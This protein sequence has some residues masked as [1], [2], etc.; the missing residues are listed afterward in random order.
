MTKADLI[1]SIC[2]D[3]GGF[4]RKEAAAITEVVFDAMKEALA[5]GSHLKLSGFGTFAVR[6]KRPRTGRNPRTGQ[7]MTITARKVLSFKA[8]PLLKRAV[9]KS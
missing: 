5:A 9:N 1:T 8:S 7:Q 6:K 4:T 2:E 3:V